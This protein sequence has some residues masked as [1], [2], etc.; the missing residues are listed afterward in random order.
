MHDKKDPYKGKRI[1]FCRWYLALGNPAEA[2][3]RAGCPPDTAEQ[4]GLALLHSA[5]C[6][7][8]LRKLAAAPA[9]PLRSLVIAGLARLAFGSANDAAKLAFSEEISDNALR[10]LDLFHVVSIKHDRNGFEVKLADRQHA[11]E[12]LLKCAAEAESE[13]AAESLLA[14]LQGEV[15]GFE[16]DSSVFPEAA[17]CDGLVEES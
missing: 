16:T 13:Q 14:A 4:D 3:V 6:R 12:K 2:A 7:S 9:L 8:Y 1:P 15:N 10:A 17:A 11:M 5:Y